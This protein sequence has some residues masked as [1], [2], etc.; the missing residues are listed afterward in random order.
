MAVVG[1]L[2]NSWYWLD[3][4]QSHLAKL[5]VCDTTHSADSGSLRFR[6][7]STVL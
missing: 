1:L 7:E 4:L 6:T 3:L 2:V 5:Q